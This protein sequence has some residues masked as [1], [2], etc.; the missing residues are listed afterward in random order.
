MRVPLKE[1]AYKY[2][3]EEILSGRL[4]SNLPVVENDICNHLKISRTPV[5]EALKQL[6]AEGLVQK[7]AD[8]GCFVKGIS[9]S[10]IDEICELRKIF[11]VEAL[12]YSIERINKT[13]IEECKKLLLDLNENS[14]SGYFFNADKSFHKLIIK[15]CPNERLVAY[16]HD[17][18]KQIERF[19]RLLAEEKE[20]YKVVQKQHLYLLSVLET[21]NYEATAKA[22]SDHIDELHDSLLLIYRNER[23]ISTGK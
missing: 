23:M 11:E 14:G 12:R 7:I 16:Y 17:L 18:E 15:Y 9:I 3:L 13:D 8:R 22:L 21:K 20:H 6:E 5:R 10:D 4:K 19:Q 1:K 2:I